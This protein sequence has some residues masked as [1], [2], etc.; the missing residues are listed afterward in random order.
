MVWRFISVYGSSY[1]EGKLDFIQELN[2]L[3]E[4][5]DG[6]TLIGGDF[7]L[8]ADKNE[9]NNGLVNQKWVYLFNEWIHNFG[10]LELKKF[11]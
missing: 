5:W 2:S 8:V 1:E 10:L 6:P 4:N 11:I 7:N 3:L 9:K